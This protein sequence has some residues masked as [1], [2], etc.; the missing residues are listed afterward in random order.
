MNI[1][2]YSGSKSTWQWQTKFVLNAL[3]YKNYKTRIISHGNV[4]EF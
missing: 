3:A 2:Q 1:D 4:L